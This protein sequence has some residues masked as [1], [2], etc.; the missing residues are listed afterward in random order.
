MTDRCL[1]YALPCLCRINSRSLSDSLMPISPS[2][3]APV[4]SCSCGFAT[5]LVRIFFAF[6]PRLKTYLFTN[7]S[8]GTV[9]Y[10]LS[11][12]DSTDSNTGIVTSEHIGFTA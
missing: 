4:T 2:F 10:S 8:H 12:T 3:P 9:V 6:H 11:R 7:P 5:F 1:Q